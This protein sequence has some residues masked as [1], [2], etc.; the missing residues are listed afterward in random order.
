M[1][2]VNEKIMPEDEVA[3][4]GKEVAET[5]TEN[6][7]EK[8]NRN[9]E[10]DKEDKEKSSDPP[11]VGLIEL[12]ISWHQFPYVYITSFSSSNFVRPLTNF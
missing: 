3:N 8:N 11:P 5:K 12:V 4:G 1:T 6:E 2:S 10:A 9:E 7:L